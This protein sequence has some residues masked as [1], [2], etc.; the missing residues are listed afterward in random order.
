MV[1]ATVPN[2]FKCPISLQLMKDP[3]T[4]TT[5]QTYERRSIE[6][7]FAEG[8]NT[9]PS[10]MQVLCSMDIAPNHTMQRL[11]EQWCISN[12]Y[13]YGAAREVVA[14]RPISCNHEARRRPVVQMLL[15]VARRGVNSLVNLRAMRNLAKDLE[16][17]SHN[18]VVLIEAGAVPILAKFAFSPQSLEHVTACE[19]ALGILTLLPL[20]DIRKLVHIGTKKLTVI[21]WLLNRGSIN[22]RVNAALFL[23][24][25]TEE[26]EEMKALV[27]NT[28]AIFE[29]LVQLLKEDLYQKAIEAGLKAILAIVSKGQERNVIR[30]VDAG[31]VF[32]M[33]D[34]LLETESRIQLQTLTKLMELLCS[35]PEGREA[36]I[37]HALVVPVLVRVI[38]SHI[39]VA[40]E[41]ALSCLWTICQHSPDMSVD[42]AAG[43]VGIVAHLTEM[44]ESGHQI[45]ARTKQ[46]AAELLRQ[47]RHSLRHCPSRL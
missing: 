11:I 18:R 3:V 43:Q 7:W 34:R 12:N 17:G 24:S 25:L 28:A 45:N 38:L 20:Q 47:L 33:V 31:V 19:E 8:H 32:A 13:G 42:E 41:S 14:F 36:L 5:G 23:G 37:A 27:G 10:T 29:G 1:K 30:A 44:V 26:D 39:P 15:E 22:G 40:S 9:C 35:K 46:R 16:Q 6:T 2:F 21:S 4:L